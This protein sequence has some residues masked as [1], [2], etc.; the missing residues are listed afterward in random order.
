[1]YIVNIILNFN[2]RPFCSQKTKLWVRGTSS[3]RHTNMLSSW[4]LTSL[5][6]VLQMKS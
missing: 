6:T 5:K 2:K 1:M 4:Q 3:H